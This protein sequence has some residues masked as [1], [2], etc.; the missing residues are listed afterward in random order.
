[1]GVEGI[2]TFY[3]PHFTT[4]AHN[5]QKL[6]EKL[7]SKKRKYNDKKEA[8]LISRHDGY[9]IE[10]VEMAE[11]HQKHIDTLYERTMQTVVSQQQLYA[12]V[13]VSG[14]KYVLCL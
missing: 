5:I 2:A 7:L 14:S 6:D 11:K 3:I 12:A 9:G 4:N 1:V 13:S 8:A 10:K